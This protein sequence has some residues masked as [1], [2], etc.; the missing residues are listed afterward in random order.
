MK[1][2]AENL[3]LVPLRKVKTKK[4]KNT[5]SE[6]NKENTSADLKDVLQ[7]LKGN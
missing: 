5:K 6:Q 7:E 2:L 1:N 3:V 4:H